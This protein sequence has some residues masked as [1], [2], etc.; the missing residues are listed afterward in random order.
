[1]DEVIARDER[2]LDEL[3][4]AINAG[5]QKV[6][7]NLQDALV[8]ALRTG[9][10]LR[11][12]HSLVPWGEWHRWLTQ[13]ITIPVST[14]QNY[15]RLA[16]FKH[17]LPEALNNYQRTVNRNGTVQVYSP[18]GKALTY[19]KTIG[20]TSS[21]KQTPIRTDHDEIRRLHASGATQSEIST[22]LQ[23]SRPT[24]RYATMSRSDQRA[25]RAK[26][27]R[28]ANERHMALVEKKRRDSA[29]KVGGD[30]A[31]AYSLLRRCLAVAQSARDAMQTSQ[32]RRSVDSSI[33]SLHEA[34]D[35]LGRAIREL[36]IVG[37]E[38]KVRDN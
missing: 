13:N 19:L 33:T 4:E 10:D 18:I 25:Y 6:E 15:M 3:S 36:A 35:R 23:V 5:H 26:K 21:R 32:A 14:A 7:Q 8:H 24:V 2:T 27:Q 29:K 16:E 1:M 31:E 30:I 20:A 12:A 11:Q 22:L 34:E 38:Q 9:D 37:I 28:L 17:L